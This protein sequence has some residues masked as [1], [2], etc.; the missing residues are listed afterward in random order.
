MISVFSSP[1]LYADR[2][3]IIDSKTATM[4]PASSIPA[5]I[6]TLAEFAYAILFPTTIVD[7]IQ[8]LFTVCCMKLKGTKLSLAYG[9]LRRWV[10]EDFTYQADTPIKRTAPEEALKLRR[11][12]TRPDGVSGCSLWPASSNLGHAL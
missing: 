12:G 11:S 10:I 6:S 9:L 3:W 1:L 4:T 2:A 8:A 5:T 7:E